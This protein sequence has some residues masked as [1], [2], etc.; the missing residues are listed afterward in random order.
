M[1]RYP[2]AFC[3]VLTQGVVETETVHLKFSQVILSVPLARR[4]RVV[5]DTP[6]AVDH[7]EDL[8]TVLWCSRSFDGQERLYERSEDDGH[9][10]YWAQRHCDES[11]KDGQ[12]Q[13]NLNPEAEASIYCVENEEHPEVVEL[14]EVVRLV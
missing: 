13:V 3:G 9:S 7:H 8:L 4:R 6:V 2:P 10:S 5:E 1:P 11:A 12:P 14:L